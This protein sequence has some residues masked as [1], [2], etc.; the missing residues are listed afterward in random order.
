MTTTYIYIYIGWDK[1]PPICTSNSQEKID[2]LQA[3]HHMNLSKKEKK[4]KKEVLYIHWICCN[5]TKK[6]NIEASIK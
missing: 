1:Q 3:T 5:I 2:N 6:L 4:K